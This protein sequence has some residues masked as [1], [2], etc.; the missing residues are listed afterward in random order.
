MKKVIVISLCV[1]LAACTVA[2]AGANLGVAKGAIHVRA[3]N[4]KAGCT[5][6]LTTC[7]DIVL[8][9]PS[10][11][12]DAFPVFYDLVEYQGIEY[13]ITWPA[14]AYSAGFVSCS[15]LAIG[16]I[17]WSGQGASHAWTTCQHGIAA[18]DYLW[19]YADGPGTI[20][21]TGHPQH[22]SAFIVDCGEQAD[23]LI[24]WGCA[25]VFGGAS[26]PASGDACGE[27]PSPATI[28]GTW[29]QIKSLFQ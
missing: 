17:H 18:P 1:V 24:G 9:E 22:G 29:G 27:L 15:D 16:E 4:A 11:D 13:G 26:D 20:C 25:G 2:F 6:G 23:V 28:P 14:W 8:I 10:S 19:L 7:S 12:I 3:H 5:T 21:L